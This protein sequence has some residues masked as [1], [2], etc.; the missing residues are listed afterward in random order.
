MSKEDYDSL[1]KDV[2]RDLI[3]QIT[4]LSC[5]CGFVCQNSCS[6]ELVIIIGTFVGSGTI[7]CLF[8]NDSFLLEANC[9]QYDHNLFEV[10]IW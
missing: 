8:D 5:C 1:L 4:F 7:C 2:W 9:L 6:L 3:H 10:I